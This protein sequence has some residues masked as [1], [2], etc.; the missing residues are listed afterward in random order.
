MDEEC[1]KKTQK[2]LLVRQEE[3]Q[4]TLSWKPRK[5]NISEERD[6]KFVK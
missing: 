6:I 3:N 4:N 2:E 1:T 5:E